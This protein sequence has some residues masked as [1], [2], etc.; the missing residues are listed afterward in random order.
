MS[1]Y[2][3]DTL[4]V[5]AGYN[6]SDHRNAV[7]VPIYQTTAYELGDS[8]RADRLFAF[9]E[10]DPIYTRLSNPTVDV[11]EQ[12]ITA[13]HPGAAASIALA[14]GMAAVTYAL[15]NAAGKGGRILTTA[16]LYGGTVDSFEQ[17]FDEYGIGVDIVEN[18]DDISEFELKFTDDTKAVFLE[19]LTN[20][21]GTIPD[22]ERIAYIAHQKGA[23]LIVDNTVA[24]PYLMNPFSH[25]ADV[26]VYSATKALSGHGNVIAGIVVESG[27]FDY[28]A[29]RH[30]QFTKPLW[31]L[32]DSENRK[33]HILE[34]FPDAPFTGRIRAVHLNYLGAALGPFDAY[35]VLIG[36]ETLS[37]RVDKQV[38]NARLVRAFLEKN[39][40]VA[41]LRHPEGDG[42]AYGALR[43]KYFPKGVGSLVSF[44]FKGTEEQRRTFLA[45]TEV[46]S[47]QANI[48][49][50]RSLI[51]NPAQTTHVELTERQCELVGLSPDTVR[52]S[53]GLEDPNDL[54]KD[55]KGAFAK[56]FE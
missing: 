54:I 56:A 32:R 6:P 14:S 20:P 18:P 12:R 28:G 25:E 36:L 43:E 16:R 26:V 11:L 31:F 37:E 44:G 45:S 3:F 13:L 2:A 27:R 41:W 53:V 19:T 33:R 8:Y 5:R 48:G 17:I 51:I 34:I 22:L 40:H 10:D 23:T 30:P 47:Y 24:T 7:S 46:F 1:K 15:L 38:K 52:L 21:F 9:E 4:K 42:S 29:G 55:L 49:D 35:L 50:A 39:E